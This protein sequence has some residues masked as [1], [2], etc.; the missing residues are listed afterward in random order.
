[1]SDRPQIRVLIV[2]DEELARDTV[3]LL[4]EDVSDFEVIGEAADGQSAVES[5]RELEPDLVFLD[6]QMP[7]LTGMDVVAEI[8]ASNMPAVVFATAYDEYAVKAF[9]ASAI[10][11]LIKPF[12]DE[13]FEATL[14]R[15]RTQFRQKRYADLEK[16]FRSLL[17]EAGSGGAGRP[18]RFMVKERG[19]IRFVDAEDVQWVEA[20]GDY[21]VLHAGKDNLM[22]R[23][24]MTDMEDKLDPDSFVRVHRSHI[25]NINFVREIKSYFH[26]DYIL[27][28]NDGTELKVSRRYWPDLEALLSS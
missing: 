4:L 1:M 11:Y 23:D 6:V 14:E 3:R 20:A 10:D 8:G 25:V 12:S 26:G 19:T 28:L 5:I 7:V 27:Y 16:R 17:G 13:R 18:S 2:D 22:L 9:E 15:V 24:T 21:V